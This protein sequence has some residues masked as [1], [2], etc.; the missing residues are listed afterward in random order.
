MKNWL[1]VAVTLA[2]AGGRPGF[3]QAVDHHPL[4]WLA[5]CWATRSADRL[6]EEQ[7]MAPR[8]GL[9]LGMARTTRGDRVENYE[10]TVIRRDAGR[11]VYVASVPGQAATTFTA[12]LESDTAV[13]FRNMQ[14]DFPKEVRYARRGADSLIASIA[15]D[16]T[17]WARRTWYRFGRVPC[18]QNCLAGPTE[19]RDQ[20]FDQLGGDQGGAWG[21]IDGRVELDQVGRHQPAPKPLNHR[22]QLTHR[23]STRLRMCDPGRESRVEHVEIEGEIDRPVE[24][25][26]KRTGPSSH[27]VGLDSE[28][29][30][31]IALMSGQGPDPNL[32]Q[33]RRQPAFHD[34]GE[35]AGMGERIPLVGVIEVA[36]GVEV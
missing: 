7:W 9:M 23:E 28:T 26:G 20:L 29:R 15:G 31:L 10:Q 14:H 25:N 2:V 11:L 19:G 16:S 8:G 1:P 21:V 27:L 36:V 6:V 34:S 4:G 35:G 5:G 18:G 30:D 12:V 24:L 3:A 17:P 13:I 32:D 33:A 22:D